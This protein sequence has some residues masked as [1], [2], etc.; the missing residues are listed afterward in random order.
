MK[1]LHYRCFKIDGTRESGWFLFVHRSRRIVVSVYG[2]L[3]FA[4]G[5]CIRVGLIE[6]WVAGE[7]ARSELDIEGRQLRVAHIRGK[8]DVRASDFTGRKHERQICAGHFPDSAVRSRSAGADGRTFCH[9][10]GLRVVF[11][12]GSM[13]VWKVSTPRSP[14]NDSTPWTCVI[15]SP[16]QTCLSSSRPSIRLASTHC[17]ET[18]GDQF[19]LTICEAGLADG[20]NEHRGRGRRLLLIRV[21]EYRSWTT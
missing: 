9:H 18:F 12:R 16:V 14:L 3:G 21:E 15:V 2:G 5:S 19:H 4:S 7:S 8:L 1:S 17:D 10:W 13:S 6:V 11:S 20:M